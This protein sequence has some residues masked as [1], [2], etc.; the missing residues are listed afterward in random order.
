[1]VW[2]NML[3]FRGCVAR[4]KVKTISKST[5][6]IL[7]KSGIN[8]ETISDE[9]CCGSVLLR[10]GFFEDAQEQMERNLE[11]LKGKKI[12]VSCA[13][14]YKTFK[15]DYKEILGIELD[16]IH[17]SQFF[18]DL[19]DENKLILEKSKKS[20]KKLFKATYHDPCHLGRHSG[21]YEAPREVLKKVCSLTEMEHIQ[22]NARCCGSGG[23]VKSAYPEIAETIAQERIKEAEKTGSTALVTSCPFC[24]LNLDQ[25]DVLDVYDLSE[26]LIK[27][28]GELKNE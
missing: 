19:I 15:N 11:D 25:S 22:E 28:L 20:N 13:G 27:I 3:Y 6:A 16:V 14:C 2:C 9:K 21:E 26:F 12:L 1:M 7:V 5:E 24:K 8:F 10:T 4:E 17:T 18:R 23:G